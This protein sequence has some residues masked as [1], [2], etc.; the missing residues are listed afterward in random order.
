ME[1]NLGVRPRRRIRF[2]GPVGSR[3]EANRTEV[4]AALKLHG[5]TNPRVFGSVARNEDTDDSDLD[6]LA[7][8]P[9]GMGLVALGRLQAELEEILGVP[10]DIVPERDLKP[11]VRARIEGDVV[12]L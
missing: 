4:M 12:P 3:L 10:V 6:L 8:L 2:R 9:K 11:R 7:S 1:L 5:V